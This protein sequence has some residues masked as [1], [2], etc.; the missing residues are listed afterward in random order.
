MRSGGLVPVGHGAERKLGRRMAG[1]RAVVSMSA[2]CHLPKRTRASRGGDAD[3][4][5]RVDL[6]GAPPPA[7]QGVVVAHLPLPVGRAGIQP[8]SLSVCCSRP[9]GRMIGDGR[10]RSSLWPSGVGRWVVVMTGLF[11]CLSPHGLS[12]PS[13]SNVG[14]EGR[15]RGFLL[16]ESVP[17][18][19]CCGNGMPLNP[20]PGT[21][22]VG[23]TVATPYRPRMLDRCTRPPRLDSVRPGAGC[24]PSHHCRRYERS[25]AQ[26]HLLLP[27]P[28]PSQGPVVPPG[29]Q[30]IHFRFLVMPI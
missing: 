30:P 13:P 8:S 25:V 22:G 21:L 7:V 4:V 27:N 14:D 2:G 10:W 24:G 23:D 28:A 18:V 29:R 6:A 16:E 1:G 20:K 9:S 11:W 5:R 15:Q 3:E 17:L 26:H 19:A 12:F